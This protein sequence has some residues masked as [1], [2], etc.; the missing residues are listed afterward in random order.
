MNRGDT[1]EIKELIPG[2]EVYFQY[3]EKCIKGVFKDLQ[4]TNAGNLVKSRNR[5]IQIINKKG[6]E[7]IINVSRNTK[8][9]TTED[10]VIEYK[11][12][13]EEEQEAQKKIEQEKYLQYIN[14]I[15]EKLDKIENINHL[16]IMED[17]DIEEIEG[18]LE[19]FWDGYGF[20]L[21]DGTEIE[22]AQFE[23]KCILH[24]STNLEGIDIYKINNGNFFKCFDCGELL[25]NRNDL[26][27]KYDLMYDI[28]EQVLFPKKWTEDKIIEWLRKNTK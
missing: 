28:N 26:I 9:F 7:T 16:H 2:T 12:K 15:K 27:E 5:L 22:M 6:K 21:E 1:M 3:D 17:V 4:R 19:L 11:N 10:E 18:Y 25:V 20:I 13:I 23:C 8:F 24:S 14:S